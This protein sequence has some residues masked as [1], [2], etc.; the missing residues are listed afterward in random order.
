MFGRLYNYNYV[1]AEPNDCGRDCVER[2]VL[3]TVRDHAGYFRFAITAAMAIC[4]RIIISSIIY[5]DVIVVPVFTPVV[6]VV[7]ELW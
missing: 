7:F 5:I 4:G 3:G 1:I 6:V 2:F